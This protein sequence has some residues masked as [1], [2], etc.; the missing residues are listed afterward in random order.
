MTLPN[1][2][3]AGADAQLVVAQ[4]AIDREAAAIIGYTDS[5]DGRQVISEANGDLL[6]YNIPFN[7]LVELIE[8][9]AEKNYDS[10]G[11]RLK[12]KVLESDQPNV[13]VNQTY[14][15]WFFDKNPSLKEYILA[16][17]AEQRVRFAAALDEYQDDP[18]ELLPDGSP[19]Y[20][21]APVL[22]ELHRAVEPLGILMRFENRFVRKTRNGAL[23]HKLHFS[24]AK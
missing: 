18:L 13:R 3:R 15:L 14:T 22:L 23:L 5:A 24:L 6:P 16:E 19:K 12:V 1:Q 20:K 4:Q 10:R 21:A 17:M 2:T 7:A 11:F 8:G 9:K